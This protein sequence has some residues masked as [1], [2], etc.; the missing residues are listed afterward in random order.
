ML[1]QYA[2]IPTLIC[3]LLVSPIHG[4]Q[5][6][7][8]LAKRIAE[9]ESASEAVRAQYLYKQQLLIEEFDQRNARV[10]YYS[11]EREIIFS[12]TGERSE[13][14]TKPA[15]NRLVRLQLTPEDFR[16]IQEIQPLLLTKDRLWLYQTQPRG[17]ETIDGVPCWVLAVQPRQILDGQRLFEGLLWAAQSDFSVVRSEGRAVPQIITKKEENLFPRFTT[18]R[19]RMNHGD[20]FPQ[21]T[22][23]DDTLPFRSGPLRLRMKVTFS[24]YQRFG[25]DTN[26]RFEAPQP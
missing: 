12:P 25:A 8:D 7:R 17:E 2:L 4:A 23:A 5:P 22:F 16:D 24:N 11:E 20:W 14:L 19:H 9:R 21:A 18:I 1:A 13:K 6:P 15:T 10:G 26:I 3:T